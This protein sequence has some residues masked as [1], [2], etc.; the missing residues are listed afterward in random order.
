MREMI[1][2]LGRSA[3]RLSSLGMGK[4]WSFSRNGM[5]S[6]IDDFTQTIPRE[7][8]TGRVLSIS[9]SEQLLDCMGLTPNDYVEANYPDA[10]ILDLP[11]KDNSFDWVISDQVFEH[12]VGDPQQAMDETLR[13]LKPGGQ[14]LHTTCFMMAYHGSPGALEDYWRFSASGLKFL[15]RRA[16]ETHADGIG[17]PLSNFLCSMGLAFEPIPTARWHPLN[18]I[19]RL[20]SNG[21][22]YTVWVYAKK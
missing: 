18:K 3:V 1:N 16:S 17:H 11:F 14:L 4:R 6:Q 21:H 8:R 15:A 13:V 5:Y 12:I 22:H 7:R 2:K 20:R 10:N 9:H 19:T